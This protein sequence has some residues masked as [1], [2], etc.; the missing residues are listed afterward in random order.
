MTRI[1]LVDINIQVVPNTLNSKLKTIALKKNS[2]A[3]KK[4]ALF[5]HNTK[6]L[7]PPGSKCNLNPKI[8]PNESV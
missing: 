3:H 2:N 8:S 7:H 5:T 6:G 1:F 4:V